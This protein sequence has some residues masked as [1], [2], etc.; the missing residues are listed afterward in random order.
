MGMS[1]STYYFEIGK[2]DVVE[3]RNAKLTKEIEEIFFKNNGDYGVRRVYQ[4]LLNQK[5]HVNH[6]RV[7]RIMHNGDVNI[8]AV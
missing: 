5:Y 3:E 4:E 1:R 8:F 7:Q 6:K 2:T